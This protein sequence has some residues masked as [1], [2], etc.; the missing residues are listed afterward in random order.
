M[1]KENFEEGS[2]SY[3]L[4]NQARNLAGS[5]QETL[6]VTEMLQKKS[7]EFE[8]SKEKIKSMKF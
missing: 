3:K 8:E 6:I 1:M 4:A 7:E 5:F 2:P